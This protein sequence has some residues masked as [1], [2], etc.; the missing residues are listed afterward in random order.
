MTLGLHDPFADVADWDRAAALRWAQALDLRASGKDQTALRAELVRATGLGPGGTALE[1]GCGTGVLLSELA[2]VVGPGGRALGVEPQPVLAGLAD[3]RIRTEQL[4]ATTAVLV[5]RGERLPVPS[6]TADACVAQTVLVHLPGPVLAATL[7]EMVRT[8][9]P[10]GRVVSVDQDGD[11]WT[12]DHPDRELTRRIIR[13]NSDQR[14]ADG[15]TGRR[16]VRLFRAAGLTDVEIRVL[17]HV[18]TE[19]GSYLFGM[20]LRLAESA[21]EV[22]VLTADEHRRWVDQ[23]TEQAADVG[24]F[25]S[26]N[27]YCC[28]GRR[29]G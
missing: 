1:V 13:F 23:L 28:A 2:R 8:V 25:A 12:I 15:W 24:F 19:P 20:A 18:D 17:P 10:G 5:G 14:Y 3:A 27:N 4:T 7:A 16:L 22:G 6:A 11:T 29:P 26:I 21:Q 9:R